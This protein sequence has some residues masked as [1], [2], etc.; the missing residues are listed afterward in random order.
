V[1]HLIAF[2]ANFTPEGVTPE[3][4]E[5]AEGARA[6]SLGPLTRVRYEQIAPDPR[7][8]EVAMDKVL[9]MW[10]SQPRFT[11]AQLHSIRVRTLIAAGEH[12]IIQ[13]DHTELLAQAIPGA[14]LWIV[15]GAGHAVMRDEPD[16]VASTVLAFLRDRAVGP[17][18][19]AGSGPNGGTGPHPAAPR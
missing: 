19:T 6:A 15:P 14:R 10:R 7:H 8:Y 18:R 5:W 3:A 11:L 13:R 1:D 12:D 17:E 9:A 2:G 16:L 4:A